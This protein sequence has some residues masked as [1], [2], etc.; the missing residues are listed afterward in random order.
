MDVEKIQKVSELAMDLLKQG[1]APDKEAAVE[2]AEK[3]LSNGDYPSLK[4]SVD[5]VKEVEVKSDSKESE[6]P[7]EQDEIKKIL[8][9]N[10]DFTVK[11]MKEFQKQIKKVEDFLEGLKTEMQ[12]L[13]SRTRNLETRG[14]N[15][16]SAPKVEVKKEDT[17]PPV[18]Q[19]ME[20]GS[21]S[22]PVHPRSG[23]YVDTDVSI[24]K[25]F[26]SGSKSQS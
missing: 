4:D 22:A 5:P 26:Y 3:L 23:D 20:N 19:S 9:K 8:K 1:L 10:V 18:Q 15:G 13:S 16:A 21:S 25:F 12:T 11:T 14:A 2:Q 7:L 6:K 24:E 17:V